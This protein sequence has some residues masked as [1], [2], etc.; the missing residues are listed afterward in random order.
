[1]A[2]NVNACI[3]KQRSFTDLVANVKMEAKV[4]E[5]N[6][7]FILSLGSTTRFVKEP[8]TIELTSAHND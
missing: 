5:G 2:E 3:V 4:T 8:K 7:D 1:M 6:V